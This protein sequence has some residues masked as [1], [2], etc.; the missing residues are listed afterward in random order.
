MFLHWEIPAGK[1]VKANSLFLLKSLL[2]WKG[3]RCGRSCWNVGR[4]ETGLF[5][6]L[7]SSFGPPCWDCHWPQ[8]PRIPSPEGGSPGG[9][10]VPSLGPFAILPAPFFASD[11]FSTAL[12]SMWGNGALS[13]GHCPLKARRD[14]LPVG[15]APAVG[16]PSSPSFAYSGESCGSR[17]W[18]SDIR[19]PLCQSL[20]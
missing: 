7:L 11:A 16:P 18:Q 8:A 12:F 14:L 19:L 15:A 1:E 9:S 3:L 20:E 4:K 17:I 13:Q 2:F 5:H 10:T 6:R